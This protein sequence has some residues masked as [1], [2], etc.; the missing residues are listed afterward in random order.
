MSEVP[1]GDS[2]PNPFSFK[3]FVKR[4]STAEK[5]ASAVRGQRSGRPAKKAEDPSK[6]KK[7]KSG[8]GGEVEDV[9]FPDLGAK[10][11]AG[12]YATA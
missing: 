4:G 6:R 2:G 8:G 10:S 5:S 7:K 1:E 3:N 9:P 11:D 12:T